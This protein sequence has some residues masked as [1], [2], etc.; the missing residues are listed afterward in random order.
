MKLT[1]QSLRQMIKEESDKIKLQQR[2]IGKGKQAAELRAQA[3]GVQKGEIVE[4]RNEQV[5]ESHRG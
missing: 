5:E 3:S 2:G 4:Y 1:K